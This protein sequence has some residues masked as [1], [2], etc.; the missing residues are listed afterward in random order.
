MA[1]A[2]GAR[3]LSRAVAGDVWR[4]LSRTHAYGFWNWMGVRCDWSSRI[5]IG[6]HVEPGALFMD[7]SRIGNRAHVGALT[8][9][10][11]CVIENALVGRL[12]SIG[13]GCLV[14]PNDHDLMALSSSPYA[15][16]RSQFDELLKPSRIG[17]D[18]WIGAQCI[19]L[20]GVSIGAGSVIGANSVVT[21]DIP[22]FAIAAGSP[23][24]VLR[25]R[26]EKQDV[27]DLIEH[28]ALQDMRKIAKDLQRGERYS[29]SVDRR[30]TKLSR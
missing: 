13:P 20:G 27:I 2:E 8:Y 28:A 9:G 1:V 12:C 29:N 22:A 25:K 3:L 19:V 10:S 16:D 21:D 30:R 11:R 4:E 6:A 26:V 24:R 5:D 23:A 18:V 15:Y 14:G 7:G 17:H